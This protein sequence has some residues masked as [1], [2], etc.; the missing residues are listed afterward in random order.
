MKTIKSLLIG[1]AIASSQA[2]AATVPFTWTD[3][4]N[5]N[6]DT[7][8]TSPN[9]ISYTFDIKDGP[10][11]Y[12]PGVDSLTG[13]SLAINLYD[14]SSDVNRICGFLGC[15]NI[16]VPLETAY[17]NMPGLGLLIFEGD[18]TYFDLSGAE[19]GGSSV[20]GWAQ[21]NANGTLDMQIYALVGDFMFGDATLTANGN[22]VPEPGT[23]A[24]A[25][26]ALASIGFMR[27]RRIY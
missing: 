13:Y 24:L 6:P 11:G 17:I 8:L 9:S 15:F 27:R 4:Y 16:P 23:L 5:P 26:L 12:R 10:F 21:L 19:E 25:G 3:N 14:D 18:R 7:L 22:R 20:A 2:F 1:L